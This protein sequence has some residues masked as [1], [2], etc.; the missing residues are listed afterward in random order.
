MSIDVRR[1]GNDDGDIVTE[2]AEYPGLQDRF[3][4]LD[5]ETDAFTEPENEAAGALYSSLGATL[6]L[7]HEWD[8]DYTD[9]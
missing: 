7:V 8:L 2:L 1:I 6:T 9:R 5:D 3:E 4:L